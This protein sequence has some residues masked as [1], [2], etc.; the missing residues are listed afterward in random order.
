MIFTLSFMLIVLISLSFIEFRVPHEVK[1]LVTVAP[2]LPQ[3][4]KNFVAES[5]KAQRKKPSRTKK[6]PTLSSKEKEI[7]RKLNL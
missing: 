4:I 2:P 3:E 7:M 1:S 6:E 5:H